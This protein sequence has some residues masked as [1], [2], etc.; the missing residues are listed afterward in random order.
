[1]LV[2]DKKYAEGWEGVEVH[3]ECPSLIREQWKQV[4]H[5]ILKHLVKLLTRKGKEKTYR[6]LTP[7]AHDVEC[8]VIQFDML[9]ANRK[10]TMETVFP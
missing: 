10:P 9:F 6:T 1:M 8:V 3:Q 2:D 5:G 4:V 7:G